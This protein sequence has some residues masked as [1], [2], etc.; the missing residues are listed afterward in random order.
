M[1]KKLNSKLRALVRG[2][3]RLA[4]VTGVAVGAGPSRTQRLLAARRVRVRGLHDLERLGQDANAVAGDF[5]E[6]YRKVT[7]D[8]SLSA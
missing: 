5:A 8:R 7:G 2:M 1:T 3:G 6:A 4:D